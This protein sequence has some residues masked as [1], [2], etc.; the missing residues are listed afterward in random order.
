[1]KKHEWANCIK[2]LNRCQTF[3]CTHNKFLFHSLDTA[4]ILTSTPSRTL[5]RIQQLHTLRQ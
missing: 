4:P 2:S 1:M 5:R 3:L